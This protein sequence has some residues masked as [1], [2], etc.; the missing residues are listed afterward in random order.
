MTDQKKS[1]QAGREQGGQGKAK[2]I[3]ES[4]NC[5]TPVSVTPSDIN[6]FRAYEAAIINGLLATGEHSLE[7]IR[8]NFLSIR[9]TARKFSGAVSEVHYPT[10]TCSAMTDTARHTLHYYLETPKP[11]AEVLAHMAALGFEERVTRY[12]VSQNM[13]VYARTFEL[14]E[15]DGVPMVGRRA[16][17]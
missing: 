11:L 5:S 4:L 17:K 6:G 9:Q 7:S 10:G 8:D 13:G 14:D 12:T 15:V 3:T 16:R 2:G 1:R